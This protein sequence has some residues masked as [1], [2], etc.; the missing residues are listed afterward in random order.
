MPR[1]V[2]IRAGDSLIA[3]AAVT[4]ADVSEIDRLRLTIHHGDG[5]TLIAG[6]DAIEALM[7]IKPSALEG[8][9]LRWVRHAWAVHN[10]IG[11]PLMQLF[12]FFGRHHLAIRIHD[13]TVPRP[14]L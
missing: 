11:H 7:L 12:S 9:R 13:A 3:L 5:S 2:F 6:P 10:L 8:R 14:V 1:S 4:G